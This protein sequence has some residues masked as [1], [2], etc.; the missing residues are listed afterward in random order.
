MQS[1]TP[2]FLDS[3]IWSFDF[4]E[5]YRLSPEATCASL[6]SPILNQGWTPPSDEDLT[7]EIHANFHSTGSRHIDKSLL[8]DDIPR[9]YQHGCG[10]R[11]FS[12]LANLKRHQQE[13]ERKAAIAA[14]PHCGAR[15]YRKWTRDVHVKRLS[16]NKAHRHRAV[17]QDA[18]Q[19]KRS[20][21][22]PY[23]QLQGVLDFGMPVT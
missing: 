22:R 15:F 2:D 6:S 17:Q 7:E 16:C 1:S 11:R 10:G 8:T 23:S 13:F 14:C 20:N 9:C 12:K 19:P 3:S 5:D 4:S 18:A 21:T